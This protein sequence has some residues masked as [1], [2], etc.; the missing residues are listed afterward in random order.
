MKLAFEHLEKGNLIF[1]QSDLEECGIDTKAASVYSGLLTEIIKDERGLNQDKVFSFV[2]L[3]IQEFLAALYVFLTFINTGVDLLRKSRF[4][5]ARPVPLQHKSNFR[6]LYQRAVDK[7]LQS[8]NGHL[9]LFVRFLLGLSLE[10]NQ[11]LLRGLLM[12][13]VSAPWRDKDMLVH[14]IKRKISENPPEKSIN[15]LHCLIE[16]NDQSHAKEIQQYLKSGCFFENKPS[17]SQWSALAFILLSSQ[18][19]LDMFDLKKFSA[20]DE[21]LLWLR[22]VVKASKKSL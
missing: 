8:P 11:T 4:S 22:P 19:D 9:D 2:H 14:Y 3:S 5:S 7:A 10:S 6:N 16:L 13:T 15:L 18:K 1:N 20:S 17:P 21:G 12:K